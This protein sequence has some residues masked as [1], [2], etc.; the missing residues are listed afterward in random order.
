MMDI[1]LCNEHKT[2]KIMAEL[3]ILLSYLSKKQINHMDYSNFIIWT[4]DLMRA[5]TLPQQ[6]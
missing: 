1:Q 6:G 5:K 3:I 4:I 2:I